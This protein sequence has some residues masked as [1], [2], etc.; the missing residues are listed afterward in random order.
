MQPYCSATVLAILIALFIK[1]LLM[2]MAMG[3]TA[4]AII[5]EVTSSY[6][7][8]YRGTDVGLPADKAN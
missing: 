8:C 6:A 1:G 3:I 2:G 5:S 4:I 7:D